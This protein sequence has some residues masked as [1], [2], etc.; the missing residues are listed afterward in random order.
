MLQELHIESLGVIDQLNREQGLTI[1]VVTQEMDVAQHAKRL[2]R[3]KDGHIVFDGAPAVATGERSEGPPRA[4][5]A[6]SGGSDPQSGGAWG[7]YL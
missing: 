4:S 5:S 3:L 1:I 6:P 7:Q 2:V